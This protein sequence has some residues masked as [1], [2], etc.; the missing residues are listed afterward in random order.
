MPGI[1][2]AITREVH[3]ENTNLTDVMTETRLVKLAKL[4]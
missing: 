2:V 4:S 3:N 1:H